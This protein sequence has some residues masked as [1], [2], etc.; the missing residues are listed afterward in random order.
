[1]CIPVQLEYVYV[2]KMVQFFGGLWILGWGIPP[3]V[4]VGI[5]PAAD[6][7]RLGPNEYPGEL[8]DPEYPNGWED[9]LGVWV[10][11]MG[12]SVLLRIILEMST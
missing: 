5:G 10:V 1:V 4:G 3:F 6:F 11:R 2:A 12:G 9:E 8:A 7:S